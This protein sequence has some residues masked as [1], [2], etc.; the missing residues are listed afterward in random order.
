M[1]RLMDWQILRPCKY[2]YISFEYDNIYI[3]QL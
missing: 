3:T 1:E 2:I